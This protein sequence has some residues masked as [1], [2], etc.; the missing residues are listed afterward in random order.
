MLELSQKPS[1]FLDKNDKKH[2][3][4]KCAE[5]ENSK[6][7]PT[8]TTTTTIAT[9]TTTTTT[10]SGKDQW[11]QENLFSGFWRQIS[12]ERRCPR[13]SWSSRRP[14]GF[15][16]RFTGKRF[17]KKY[18][19]HWKIC[20][21]LFK[22]PKMSQKLCEFDVLCWPGDWARP[23]KA[24]RCHFG[25]LYVVCCRAIANRN[26]WFQPVSTWSRL[27]E[28]VTFGDILRLRP[29]EK[30]WFV[31]LCGMFLFFPFV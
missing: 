19:K 4:T 8:T 21:L 29:D 20:K 3:K 17:D 2:Q 6:K 22:S 15:V 26:L 16:L 28:H 31:I 10:F 12:V 23:K 11:A 27:I 9:T 24:F 1:V 25:F 5:K 18:G 30:K 7:Q 14:R 13:Q